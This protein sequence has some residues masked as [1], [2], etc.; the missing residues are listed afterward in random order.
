[1]SNVSLKVAYDGDAVKGV[2]DVQE[3][4]PALLSIGN[5][6]HEANRVL[7]KDRATVSVRVKSDFKTGS[8]QIT[9]DVV[10]S[11]TKQIKF[12]LSNDWH[13]FTAL[14]ILEFIGLT[15]GSGK[16]LI[17]FLKWLRGRKI[18]RVTIIENGNCRIETEGDFDHIEVTEN[19]V[20]LYQDKKVRNS[21]KGTIEP[22]NKDGIDRFVVREKGKDIAQVTK[23]DTPYFE[24]PDIPDEEIIDTV[25]KVACNVVGVFFEEGLK[26]RLIMGENRINAS[27][28]D[29]EFLNALDNRAVS[30]SKGDILEVELRTKQWKTEHGLKTEYEVLRVL[31]QHKCAEQIP[32]PFERKSNS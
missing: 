20:S 3:L 30:F 16:G 13:T 10:Q 14:E 4:A 12:L 23:S 25:S 22:L 6:L 8:F 1:M 15:A 29:P 19:T 31:K 7:N 24:V 28:K 27:I 2:M 5:L 9:L 21:L 11:L 32:I 26:W 18:K 17:E